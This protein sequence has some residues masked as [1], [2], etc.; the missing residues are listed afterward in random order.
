MSKAVEQN[1]CAA[2]RTPVG[3]LRVLAC[4]GSALEEERT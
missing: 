2:L 4:R 1:E 3:C